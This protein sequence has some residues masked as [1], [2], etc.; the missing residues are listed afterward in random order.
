LL[1]VIA[2]I[3]VLIALLMPA[4]QA[5]RSAARKTSCT[6]NLK[7]IGLAFANY[8]SAQ[9]I[10]PPSSSDSLSNV[11]AYEEV[12]PDEPMHSWGTLILGYIEQAPL[13]GRMELKK[14]SLLEPNLLAGTTI[15]SSYRCPEYQ[16][17]EFVRTRKTSSPNREC[18]IGNY[19]AMG[20]STVG[21]MWGNQLDPD[22]AIIPGGEI[23]PRDITDGLSHTIFIVERR[24][25]MAASIWIDGMTAAVTALPWGGPSPELALRD[26]VALN[27]APY[28]TS[29]ARYGP[30]SMHP[31]GAYHLF[32]DGSVRFI[33]DSITPEAYV[34]L[35]TRAGNELNDD[36]D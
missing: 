35:A 30:S 21:R 1:V 18:A 8:Q 5:S 33:E 10:F 4:I 32:G 22:G 28:C 29:Y 3:G 15:I 14:S 26:Q 24:D 2:I 17:V 34:A 23:G 16:G 6:N 19:A 36:N 25:E 31:G 27:Y 13:F 12:V 11:F 7:Q 9:K 20:A